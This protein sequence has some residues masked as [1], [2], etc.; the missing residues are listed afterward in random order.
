MICALQNLGNTCYINCILQLLM[1]CQ[2]FINYVEDEIDFKNNSIALKNFILFIKDYKQNK[3]IS[4]LTIISVITKNNLFK[5]GIQYDAH[6]FLIYFL[7]IIGEEAKKII[8][9]NINCI[10][11]YKFYTIFK[12]LNRMEQDIKILENTET[13]LTLPFSKSLFESLKMFENIE[14]IENWESEKF[15]EFVNAEKQNKIYYWPKYLFIQINRY[16][17]NFNKIDDEMD[18]PFDF[19]NYKLKGTVIHHGFSNF[20]HYICTLFINDKYL[21]CDDDRIFEINKIQADSL[22]KKSYLLLYAK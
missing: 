9:K 2:N 14:N 13:I 11:E 7:D 12:N 15:K 3:K 17:S 22:I 10:F 20:G 5:M 4:P 16:D 6:E 21:I 19:N 8:N 18:I 1:Q